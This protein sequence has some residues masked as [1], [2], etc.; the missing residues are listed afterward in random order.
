M[1]ASMFRVETRW[2][3]IFVLLMSFAW[4]TSYADPEKPFFPMLISGDLS[5]GHRVA[6]VWSHECPRCIAVFKSYVFNLYW[7]SFEKK[8]VSFTFLEFEDEAGIDNFA[9]PAICAGRD[10]YSIYTL[11]YL[12]DGLTMSETEIV[13]KQRGVSPGTCQ[14]STSTRTLLAKEFAIM[15]AKFPSAAVN[16]PVLTID[17]KVVASEAEALEALRH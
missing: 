15:R 13:A 17:G 5:K 8:D 9:L 3:W 11:G 10:F 2:V 14:D 16:E 12:V 7:R 1:M 6:F 4:R